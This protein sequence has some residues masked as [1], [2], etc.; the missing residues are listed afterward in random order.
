MNE[1][2][3]DV[4]KLHPDGALE[5]ALHNDLMG[6]A[7]DR[8]AKEISDSY[9]N[10]IFSLLEPYGINRENV[11]DWVGRLLILVDNYE[12]KHFYIDGE[13]VFSIMRESFMADLVNFKIETRY[14]VGIFEELKNKK[15]GDSNEET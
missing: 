9:D 13:Y 15:A 6:E 12:T 1:I 7:R 2:K 8:I 10:F 3:I 4:S 14:R 11:G 5:L